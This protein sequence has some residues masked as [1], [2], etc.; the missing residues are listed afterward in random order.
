MPDS[1]P[2]RTHAAS[3]RAAFDME[4][5]RLFLKLYETLNLTKAAEYCHVSTSTAS[6]MLTK[7]RET[8]GD[9]L[10]SRY[11]SSMTPTPRATQLQP[12]MQSIVDEFQ[13]MLE[14]QSDVFDPASVSR[15]VRIGAVDN[16]VANYIAP[17]VPAIMRKAP[18][19]S[20]DIRSPGAH[21][22]DDLRAGTLDLIIYP[23]SGKER[24][25]MTQRITNDTLVYVVDASHPLAEAAQRREVHAA[26]VAR[27]RMVKTSLLPLATNN[28][29]GMTALQSSIPVRARENAVWTPYFTSALD[30]IAGSDLVAVAPYQWTMRAIRSGRAKNVVILG[31]PSVSPVFDVYFVWHERLEHDA[32]LPWL[33]GMMLSE[34]PEFADPRTLPVIV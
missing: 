21:I 26:D 33:R 31:R 13:R 6:R 3:P 22:F 20:L 14:T 29:N 5:A 19:L 34:L 9:E 11:H 15:T 7:L 32:L 17:A 2:P 8:F 23:I 10:F 4:G 24:G 25:I 1:T 18:G 30:F 12:L 27:Y 28:E 16:G